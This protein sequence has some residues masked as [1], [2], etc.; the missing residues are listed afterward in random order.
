[1]VPLAR[2]AANR[3][4]LEFTG[5]PRETRALSRGYEASCKCFSTRPKVLE[6]TTEKVLA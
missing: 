1:V 4:T 2:A 3:E 5:L 6:F